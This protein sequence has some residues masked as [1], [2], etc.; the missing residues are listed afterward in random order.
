[1]RQTS[2]D[3][4]KRIVADGL[5]RGLRLEIYGVLFDRG[6]MTAGELWAENLRTNKPNLQRS[7]VSAR[8]SELEEMGA[9]ENAGERECRLT[10]NRA[11]AW[12]VTT[13]LPM[14]RQL[15]RRRKC[16]PEC[17]GRGWVIP[18]KKPEDTAT[19]LLFSDE[20]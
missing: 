11:I 10:S 17:K 20:R 4:Y 1:M 9:V 13:R 7:S 2:I 15:P 19:L 16:C 8:M 3:V 14:R 5:L 6:A 12:R 18:R